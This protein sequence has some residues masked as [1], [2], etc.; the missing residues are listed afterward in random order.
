VCHPT[1]CL[2]GVCDVLDLRVGRVFG[3][4]CGVKG[5]GG[6]VFLRCRQFPQKCPR[7]P[8]PMQGFLIG[9]G[10]R[11]D[12]VLL[13]TYLSALAVEGGCE[14]LGGACG[15]LGGDGG[16]GLLRHWRWGYRF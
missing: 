5:G 10:G 2:T 7:S 4:A 16:D 14:E 1:V 8:Q 12:L 6:G 15:A 3:G 9:D 11:L 13:W